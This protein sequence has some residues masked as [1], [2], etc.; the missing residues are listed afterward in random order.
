MEE[1]KRQ[2]LVTCDFT[3]KS[4]AAL[5]HGINLS[6]KIDSE[7]TMIHI[8]NDPEKIVPARKKLEKIL[9][10]A[11]LEHNIKAKAVVKKGSIYKTINEVALDINASMVVMG[12]H[13][14]TGIQKVTGS[15]ALKV[16]SGSKVPYLVV[17]KPPVNDDF[18]NIV[19]PIDHTP[20]SKEK[21]K[22]I[23]FLAYF[24][25]PT[26]HILT[27]N[28]SLSI[29]RTKVKN[30]IY[31]VKKS[32]DEKKIE[33][34]IIIGGD[35]GNFANAINEFAETINADMIIIMI[36]RN[37][38]IGDYMFS[39]HEQKII[40]NKSGLPVLCVNPRTDLFRFDI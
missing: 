20:E 12:T 34:E 21:I 30:N 1:N 19:M 10:K 29:I 2:L 3:D 33:F 6:K 28:L 23:N 13:G 15:K 8:E 26:V 37:P 17:Q 32:F 16:I 38:N 18:R 7:I 35:K 40:A 36:S 9:E 27:P 5:L 14:M 22:V 11:S 25:K 24:Y 31:H 39:A 4:E